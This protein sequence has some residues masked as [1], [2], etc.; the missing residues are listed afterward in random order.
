MQR[1][2]I[3]A[4]DTAVEF[5]LVDRKK[6]TIPIAE[7]I[8]IADLYHSSAS[9]YDKDG[10]A[11]TLAANVFRVLF[12]GERSHYPE[13]SV[14]VLELNASSDEQR[15]MLRN[16]PFEHAAVGKIQNGPAVS[17]RGP[18]QWVVRQGGKF[19]N[20]GVLAA[21]EA[22]PRARLWNDDIP[23]ADFGIE[24]NSTPDDLVGG[25]TELVRGSASGL[26]LY[27]HGL[28]ATE[29]NS[30]EKAFWLCRDEKKGS[31]DELNFSH[32][33]ITVRQL[34]G[35]WNGS[36]PQ[37]VF[38]G[39]C[40][41]GR[42]GDG[43]DSAAQ[44]MLDEGVKVVIAPNRR[45]MVSDAIE[46]GKRFV[47]ALLSRTRDGSLLEDVE[48]ALRWVGERSMSCLDFRA[49]AWTIHTNVADLTIPGKASS[50]NPA[51]TAPNVGFVVRGD[52][53]G[54]C[55]VR[56]ATIW[57][58]DIVSSVD[59][60]ANASTVLVLSPD[61]DLQAVGGSLGSVEVSVLDH[62]KGDPPQP[63]T[64]LDGG[65][66]PLA[67]A[68]RGN[69]GV[70]CITGRDEESL[71]WEWDPT[72]GL[73]RSSQLTAASARSACFVGGRWAVVDADGKVCAPGLPLDDLTGIQSV[74]TVA[75]RHGERVVLLHEDGTVR[76]A[77]SDPPFRET[78]IPTESPVSRMWVAPDVRRRSPLS[79]ELVVQTDDGRLARLAL[80]WAL[81]R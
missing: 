50:A 6:W 9:D 23:E 13:N 3:T 65:G 37:I 61:G 14:T 51:S 63:L 15:Q 46:I 57:G 77:P 24:R 12:G 54:S 59:V 79:A 62:L 71:L 53:I 81:A 26:A 38:L 5:D 28:W 60:D 35:T 16:L 72:T 18:S 21:V 48:Q 25:L 42:A 49:S 56:A 70:R 75:T 29:A 68:R 4:S 64:T 74:Q 10:I 27:A 39:V 69:T 8:E 67:V 76:M 32:R 43:A 55:R 78:R 7:V 40:D 11:A 80:D 30:H 44:Q 17:L 20:V 31:G 36:P 66:I 1:L 33:G 22:M 52:Q 19:G 34:I 45:V 41:A 47:A 58:D 2:V 73:S